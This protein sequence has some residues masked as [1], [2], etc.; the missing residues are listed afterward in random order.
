M[1]VREIGPVVDHPSGVTGDF[2]SATD[3]IDG[4]SLG[5]LTWKALNPLKVVDQLASLRFRECVLA[6]NHLDIE[7]E[8]PSHLRKGRAASFPSVSGHLRD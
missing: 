7:K 8:F 1:L 4:D 6:E 5:E 2:D 3:I